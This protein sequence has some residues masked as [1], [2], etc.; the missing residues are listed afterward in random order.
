[1]GDSLV[2]LKD[3]RVL[4]LGGGGFIGSNLARKLVGLGAKVT[5][6]DHKFPAEREAKIQYVTADFFNQEQVGVAL[7]QVDA[8]VH[9]ISTI[10]PG[11]SRVKY[12]EGYERD[13]ISTLH[14]LDEA[15]KRGLRVLFLSSGGTVYGECDEGRIR[16]DSALN[17]INHYGCVKVCI[18]SVMRQFRRDGADFKIARISNAYGPGQNHLGGVGFIDAAIQCALEGKPVQIWGDGEN[19]RDYIYIED[20]CQILAHILAFEGSEFI[21]NVGTGVGTT[22]NEV[23]AML[24]ERFPDVSVQYL[25]QRDVDVRCN[26][27]DT[28]LSKRLFG[29]KTLELRKGIERYMDYQMKYFRYRR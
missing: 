4:V 9:T 2:D 23:I 26:I 20:V 13:F 5:C 17:P 24:K 12:M 27:L 3:L 1:M 15:A 10:T 16:E 6:F 7:A 29:V 19:R 11:N 22:Q 25:K 21:F 18:E 14:M 8:V 28:T